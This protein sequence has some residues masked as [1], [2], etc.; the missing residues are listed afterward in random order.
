[1]KIK[2]KLEDRQKLI[3][4][5]N[6]KNIWLEGNLLKVLDDCDDSDWKNYLKT[7]IE[8]DKTIRVKRLEITKRIQSQMTE[9]QNKDSAN[10]ELMAELKK[11]ITDSEE[12]TKQI[13]ETN[14]ELLEAKEEIN[15]MNTELTQALKDAEE[16]KEE[17]E[18]ARETVENDL[19]FLQKKNQTELTGI[20]VKNALYVILGVGIITT[21][22]YL[23]AI[24][25]GKE[26]QIIGS[27][28][29]NLFGILLTNAFSIVG[30]IMGV[31]Y[32]NDQQQQNQIQNNNNTPQNNN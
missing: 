1:M 17:A 5:A 20:I 13:E 32:A 16:A 2:L 28:W 30:T 27:T 6:D 31:R 29:S 23:I 15:S 24:F 26:T 8:K 25:T 7:A 22:L 19:D 12:Y 9:L 21:L 18:K 4:L 3:D 11:T 10:K 14:I